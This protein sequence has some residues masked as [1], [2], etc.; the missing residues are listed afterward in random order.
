MEYA[1]FQDLQT[2]R[3][4][5]RRL[6]MADVPLFY[7]RL[8][9][10]ETVTKHMLWQPHQSI[11]ESAASIQ[12][13]LRRYEEGRCYRWGITL[14]ED[15]ALIGILDLLAFDEVQNTC[16]FAYMLG[17][18]FWGQ[19]YGTEALLAAFDFAFSQLKVSAILADHFAENPA[20]GAVIRKA[21]MQYTGTVSGK[22]EKNGVKHDA[23]QY[24]I[25]KEDWTAKQNCRAGIY[26]RRAP[27][28]F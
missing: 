13:V 22:Y 27:A 16:S 3:L 21:G 18:A 20:S 25:T 8:G 17:E 28:A 5:L 7:T 1:A 19:G 6:T 9:S 10:S 2:A 24:R 11:S 23:P 12:K 15:D 26:P 14:L 4:H